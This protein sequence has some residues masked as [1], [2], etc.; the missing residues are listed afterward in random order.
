MENTIV[1]FRQDLRLEDNEAFIEAT[2]NADQVMFLYVFDE[3]STNIGLP[4]FRFLSESVHALRHSLR[5][6]GA[7]LI[8]RA[9]KP[10]D[11]IYQLAVETKSRWVYCNRE[12]THDEV[13]VQDRVEQKLWAI[14][15]ELRYSRGK[16][17]YHTADLPFPVTHC[18]D[19][20]AHFKKELDLMVPVRA[21]LPVPDNFKPGPNHIEPGDIPAVD[22]Q[23]ASGSGRYLHCFRGGESEGQKALRGDVSICEELPMLQEGLILSP[24]ISMG[25]L[26]PKRVFQAFDP[27]TETGSRIRQNLIMRDYLRLMGKKYGDRIFYKSGITGKQ[28][29][30]KKDVQAFQSWKKGA[31]AIPLLN[32]AMQQLNTTGWIPD[33]LRKLLASYLIRVL[34]LDWRLGASH[35]E[36]ALIDYDP[37]SNWVSWM[38]LAGVG[39]EYKEDR[40]I[41]Y[42]Q[43]WRKIDP[44][45]TYT[46]FWLGQSQTV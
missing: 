41:H 5:S 33:V 45:E 13:Y 35:F 28:M 18:P 15:R 2:R 36:Y 20:F 25:C 32:A 10:E 43:L 38:N 37:C 30:F 3:R 8:V 40:T 1:W 4:R 26:S 24:W 6:L 19:S 11:I 9:G 21:P 16:M 29:K 31:T 34:Q 17:L 42:D 23:T 27:N 12:R 7:E 44:E 22:H 46:K 14:G 39:P